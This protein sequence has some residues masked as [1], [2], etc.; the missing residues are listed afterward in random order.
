V[1]V[2]VRPSAF[3][4]AAYAEAGLPTVDVDVAVV[5]ELGAETHVIFYVDAARVEADDLADAAE[6]EH[7]QLIADDTR[8]LFTSSLDPRTRAQP[9][10]RLTVAVD[11]NEF[12]FFDPDTGSNLTGT[13][14]VPAAASA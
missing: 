7:A 8:S 6:E 13:T 11:P 12:H 10:E 1:I 3:E 5:E 9:G 14:R 2:G 4:D